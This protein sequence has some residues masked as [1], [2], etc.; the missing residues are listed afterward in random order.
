MLLKSRISPVR[1]LEDGLVN[2][3]WRQI[4][5]GLITSS[6]VWKIC[7]ERGLGDTGMGY[8]RSRV[9]ESI[10]RVP[11]EQEITTEAT[12][13]GLVEEGPAIKM[14]IAHLGID[15][16][17]VVVQKFIYG[18]SDMFGS[19]P[20]ALYCMNESEDGLS[21]NVESW[22]VKAYGCLKHMENIEAST[23]QELKAINRPFYFQ[24]L[25][26]MLN[27]DCLTGK[28]VLFNSI[29]PKDK[30]GFHIVPFRKMQSLPG[31]D[32]KLV[33][34]IVEDLKFLKERKD[35]AVSEFTRLRNKLLNIKN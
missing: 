12:A 8:I 33:Y 23:P 7:G 27:V 21:W 30:G 4:R 25:D 10:A 22:E 6:N 34:P 26:H 35:L 15:P 24:V 18:E 17:Q 5:L 28:G 11:S 31:K 20:D 19:T 2:E 3:H 9:F 14:C 32:G 1:M 16:R 13:S 29:L